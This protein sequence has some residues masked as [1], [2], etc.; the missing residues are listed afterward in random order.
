M[1][2]AAALARFDEATNVDWLL[3]W[4]NL[5]DDY[6]QL[7]LFDRLGNRD[8]KCSSMLRLWEQTNKYSSGIGRT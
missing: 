2:G 5:F 7:D 4:S 1:V 3:S 8:V 6:L